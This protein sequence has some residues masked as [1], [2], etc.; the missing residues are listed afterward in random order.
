ATEVARR[1][2]AGQARTQAERRAGVR[3]SGPL[4][5]EEPVRGGADRAREGRSHAAR[6]R[7]YRRLE[8]VA[9]R[10]SAEG[11]AASRKDEGQVGGEKTEAGMTVG[12]LLQSRPDALGLDLELLTGSEGLGR[13][14][15]SPYVQKTGLA[16]A[17]FDEYLRPGRVLVFGHSEV[18]Y[19]ESLQ[20]AER[21]DSIRRVCGH[22]VP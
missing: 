12:G 19:L 16:L 1:R 9:H 20:P 18:R 2:Q 13:R 21:T 3:A 11:D 15:T 7:Q 17:G 10:G 14:I 6:H 5:R 22:D 8:H 4:P